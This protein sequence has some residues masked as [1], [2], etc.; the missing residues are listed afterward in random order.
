MLKK[1]L[2]K[3]KKQN[4]AVPQEEVENENDQLE[5]TSEDD[6][7]DSKQGNINEIY[8]EDKLNDDKESNLDVLDENIGETEDLDEEVFENEET[9]KSEDI[10]NKVEEENVTAEREPK[11]PSL[12]S[13]LKSGLF[14]TRQGI[15]EKID[16]LLKS[17][18]K[19][20]EELLEE[21]EEILIM[22]DVGMGTTLKIIDKLRDEIKAKKITEAHEVRIILKEILKELLTT[23]E[24]NSLNISPSPAI[25]LVIGVN[26]VGK[27][28]SIGKIAHNLKSQGKKVILAAGDTFRAAAI[29]QLKV[30]GDRVG[31]NVI[32][33]QEGS[34]PAAIIFDAIQ[35]AKARKTDV[36]ICDTAGRLHNKKNLMN[37]LS[38]VFKIVDREYPDAKREVLLVL[39]ATTGQNAIQQAKTFR[40]AADIT[41]IVLTKLD[42][43]AKGG[44]ILG[45]AS[46]LGMPVK[47]VGVGEGMED[48]QPFDPNDFVEALLSEN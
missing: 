35:A 9:Y 36:L 8:E 46:E 28:T 33:H 38:K 47:L 21:L 34:D 24:D 37:E 26:G 13:K 48:L 6:L 18:G 3:F 40:E 42:G 45:I 44:V 10:P 17:Y 16:S 2:K 30:W 4:E 15:T 22:A 43:T 39:D 23:T 5:E 12:F 29:D 41:G 19:V 31:V 20:D 7:I 14:K 11:K 32:H 25:I 1:F 27:T